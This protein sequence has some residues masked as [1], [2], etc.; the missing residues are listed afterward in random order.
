ESNTHVPEY[1]QYESGVVIDMDSQSNDSP[2]D[3]GVHYIDSEGEPGAFEHTIDRTCFKLIGE[4]TVPPEK[5]PD[6]EDDERAVLV[7][8][9]NAKRVMAI[10]KN[11]NAIYNAENLIAAKYYVRGL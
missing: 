6:I 10:E 11:R 7:D 1:D 2:I 3:L 5:L 8:K 4:L 9:E